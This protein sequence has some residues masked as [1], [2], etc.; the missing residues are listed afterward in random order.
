MAARRSHQGVN[1]LPNVSFAEGDPAQMSFDQPFDAVVGRY[2]LLFQA[3]PEVMVG[4]LARHVR[5]GGLLVFHEPDWVNARSVPPAPTYDRC[6]AWINDAFLRSRIDANMISRLYAI[7][8]GAGLNA[9]QMRMRTFIAGGLA[10]G[11]F[12]QAVADLIETLVPTIER[13]SI[14]SAAEVGTATLA[15]RLQ[16]EISANDSVIVGRSEVAIWART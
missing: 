4:K 8:I 11:D 1:G 6:C 14:A 13:L 15:E 3:E 5:P 10:C 9:P 7:F 16:R 12:L 2:V